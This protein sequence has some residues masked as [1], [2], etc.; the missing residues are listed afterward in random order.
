MQKPACTTCFCNMVSIWHTRPHAHHGKQAIYT[1]NSATRCAPK[2]TTR[3]LYSV[4][5]QFFGYACVYRAH[6][7]FCLFCTHCCNPFSLRC[8]V[9]P[10]CNQYIAHCAPNVPR[11]ISCGCAHAK[12][13]HIVS[14]QQSIYGCTLRAV[15]QNAPTSAQQCAQVHT[16]QHVARTLWHCA[17]VWRSAPCTLRAHTLPALRAAQQLSNTKLLHVRLKMRFVSK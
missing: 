16:A 13:Q 11:A 5:R 3:M 4:L 15:G 8:V 12:P 6:Y 1:Y 14:A 2:H 10:N 17:T 9:C 7:L